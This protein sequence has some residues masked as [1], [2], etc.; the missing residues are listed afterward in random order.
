MDVGEEEVG[1]K[2]EELGL[3]AGVLIQGEYLYVILT[4]APG[5]LLKGCFNVFKTSELV[6]DSK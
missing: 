5:I 1:S 4:T 2:M 6:L 3:K